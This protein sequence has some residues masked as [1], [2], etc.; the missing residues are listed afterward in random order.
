PNQLRSIWIWSV[1][2]GKTRRVTSDLLHEASPA[3]DPKGEYLYYLAAREYAPLLDGFD[4]N[5]A[6]DRNTGLFALALR[7]D[8]KNPLPFESDEVTVGDE[9]KEEEKADEKKDGKKEEKKGYTKIDFDGLEGR[10]VRLPV[11]AEN[12]D[13]LSVTKDGNL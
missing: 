4:F 8:V 7:K 6:N 3:W 11:P 13:G 1:E 10:V 9:K 12:Y 5:F 2:D